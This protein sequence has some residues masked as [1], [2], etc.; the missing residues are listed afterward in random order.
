MTKS[1]SLSSATSRIEAAL[2][3]AAKARNIPD[4]S[5]FQ[6]FMG[7][8]FESERE[9]IVRTPHATPGAFSSAALMLLTKYHERMKSGR[10]TPMDFRRYK[11]LRSLF[12]NGSR[13]QQFADA[14][15]DATLPDDPTLDAENVS[16]AALRIRLISA[17][18]AGS[19]A[20]AQFL[21][22]SLNEA[23]HDP[24]ERFFLRALAA[25]ASGNLDR[26]INSSAQVPNDAIDRPRAAWLAAKAAALKGDAAT[27][28]PLLA[29]ISDGL[30]TCG[31]LHLLE[32]LHPTLHDGDLSFFTSRFPK[33]NVLSGSDP[34]Y[35]EWAMRHAQM[36][37]RQ[38]ARDRE[39]IDVANATGEMPS[40]EQIASDPVF[41]HGKAAWMVEHLLGGHGK[42][43]EVAARLYPLIVR[44]DIR[45]FRTA[46]ELMS[47][48]NES[49]EVMSLAKR[50][51]HS[52]RLPWHRD[53]DSVATVY[54][55]AVLAGDKSARKLQKLLGPDRIAPS[56]LT[57]DRMAIANRLTVMGRLSFLAA[58]ASLHEAREANDAWR[59]CG[60]ISLGLFRAIE[61]ELNARL[62]QPLAA[63]IDATT[64]KGTVSKGTLKNVLGKLANPEGK[65][66]MLGELAN[67]LSE[68]AAATTDGS[69]ESA[70]RGAMQTQFE[71][72]LSQSGKREL[73]LNGMADMI[74]PAAARYRNPPAHGQFLRLE[75]A[76][77]ALIHAEKALDRLSTWLPR[78][79]F[80]T[81]ETSQTD[82]PAVG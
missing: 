30:T 5:A 49:Q 78:T 26:T 62:V 12:S 22:A 13:G 11:L 1:T 43:S 44:G 50:F 7:A 18:E 4:Y 6:F 58:A 73:A 45:A 67:L 28:E 55:A 34:A 76:E 10:T 42:A 35:A 24:G 59:D 21:L 51:S 16:A 17:I 38:I 27:L 8:K 79:A 15:L 32:L 52:P 39:M 25:Y 2:T 69:P 61:V 82:Q 40:H 54:T 20:D 37:G 72:L 81:I 75:D 29:E 31:W 23:D 56:G 74:G 71:T 3:R 70:A 68:L 60:L 46:L 14:L 48:A 19:Y 65:G 47:A 66:M 77:A 33:K 36:M 41:H 57:A 80:R 9:A 64:L 63:G 53:V